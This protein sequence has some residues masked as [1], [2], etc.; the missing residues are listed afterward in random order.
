MKLNEQTKEDIDRAFKA[1]SAIDEIRAE[2]KTKYES[3]PG[4][5]WRFNEY[6]DGWVMALEWTLEIIDKHIGKGD[7][8]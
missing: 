5:P 4:V 8:E 1:L 6:D 3:I 2:I 7:T